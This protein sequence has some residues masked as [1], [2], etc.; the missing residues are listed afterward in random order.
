VNSFLKLPPLILLGPLIS[1]LLIFYLSQ[2]YF[3]KGLLHKFNLIISLSAF[4]SIFLLGGINIQVSD[5]SRS[6]NHLLQVEDDIEYYTAKVID[7]PDTSGKYCKVLS[8]VTRIRLNGKWQH[9]DAK[10]LMFLPKTEPLTYGQSL[11]VVGEPQ[12]ISPPLNPDEF[13]YQQHMYNKGISHQ[14]FIKSGRYFGTGL[15]NQGVSIKGLSLRIRDHLARI[16][17]SSF[18][19]RHTKALMLALMTGQREYFNENIYNSFIQIGIIHVLAISGLHVGIIYMFLIFILN[20]LS[21][22]KWSKIFSYCLK[23]SILISFAFITGL[24]PSVMRATLMFIIMIIGKML[25]RNTHIL[26]SVFLSFFLLL[27]IDPFKLFD[28]GFQLSYSA[29]LGIILFQPIIYRL[30]NIRF[31]FINWVWQLT[32]VSIAAQLGTLPFSLFY[33]KQFPTYFLL[34]N[35]FAIPFISVVTILGF[36]L[37]LISFIPNI[38]FLISALI[39]FMSDYFLEL[40]SILQSLPFGMIKPLQIGFPQG[41]MLAVLILSIYFTMRTRIW[42]ILLLSL[43][44]A[45]GIIGIDIK[46]KVLSSNKKRIIIYNTPKISCM[47]LIDGNT[48]LILVEDLSNVDVEKINYHVMNHIVGQKRKTEF[49]NYSEISKKFPVIYMNSSLLMCWNGKS[50]AILKGDADIRELKGMNIDYVL[51]SNLWQNTEDLRGVAHNGGK[52]IWDSSNPYVTR[53]AEEDLFIE[54]IHIV[55]IHGPFIEHFNFERW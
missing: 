3:T 17:D 14:H 16:I 24:S 19:D 32:S 47:E 27:V 8:K 13:D 42:K 37:V 39:E 52:I 35:I 9:T 53:M 21:R 46:D 49:A 36:I 31:L 28:V 22:K 43:G 51:I 45:I 41:V 20:P 23:I 25:N 48:S 11:M 15:Q 33:F 55:P 40:I 2:K 38:S 50:I 54:S 1:S 12:K 6:Q 34:G 18:T 5:I 44:C 30:I 26:N 29:V 7:A 10:V 4:I